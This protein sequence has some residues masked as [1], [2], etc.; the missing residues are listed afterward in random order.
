[1]ARARIFLA[2]A[3]AA[4][5]FVAAASMPDTGAAAPQAGCADMPC[6]DVAGG[7]GCPMCKGDGDRAIHPAM[8]SCAGLC[9]AMTAVLPAPTHIVRAASRNREG[10]A[11]PEPSGVALAPE[12]AP[13]RP[14][15]PA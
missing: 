3:F 5:T 9:A 1:M 14:S 2:L 11:R 13:P 12:R 8:T 7:L 10:L 4:A 6:A 15:I